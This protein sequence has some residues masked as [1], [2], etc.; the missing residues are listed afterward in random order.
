MD[1]MNKNKKTPIIITSIILIIVVAIVLV[2]VLRPKEETPI[3]TGDGNT[4]N[5]DVE[6]GSTEESKPSDS[7]TIKTETG[8]LL[9]VTDN[10]VNAYDYIL[11]IMNQPQF[12]SEEEFFPLYSFPWDEEP[13]K[14]ALVNGTGWRLVDEEKAIFERGYKGK[15]TINFSE[16]IAISSD[17]L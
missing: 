6:E 8:S 3:I 16:H 9:S 7:N 11:E 12:W 4:T 10:K 13:A 1:G 14:E 2:F 15:L 5:E 17:Q